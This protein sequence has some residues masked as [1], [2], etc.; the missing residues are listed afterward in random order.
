M[1]SKSIQHI[2]S[3]VKCEARLQSSPAY[4]LW[5]FM[6][7]SAPHRSEDRATLR[8]Y[9]ILFQVCWL[10]P[11]LGQRAAGGRSPT[12]GLACSWCTLG[13]CEAVAISQSLDIAS[14]V[15]SSKKQTDD[16]PFYCKLQSGQLHEKSL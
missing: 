13:L 8:L 10:P 3:R 9:D 6:S 11:S 1:N 14:L 4:L 16:K 15:E 12:A 2:F 7:L 5:C